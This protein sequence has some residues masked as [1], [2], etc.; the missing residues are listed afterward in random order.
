MQIRYNSFS[1]FLR[2]KFPGEK[3]RKIPINAGFQ[4]PNKNG[5]ISDEGCIFC[6]NYGS[7]PIKTF[8]KSIRKQIEIFTSVNKGKKFIAYYQAH[9]NTYASKEEIE[10]KYGIPFEYK[11]IVGL[12]IG[13]RPD[14][15]AENIYPV[16]EKIAD[17]TYLAVELGLQSIHAKSLDLLN[18]NHSYEQFL[19]TFNRLKSAGID[20]I[21]HLIVGIP[22]EKKS[23]M[24]ATVKEMNRIKPAG[25]KFHLLHVLK[26]TKL[27]DMYEDGKIK[28]MEK[29]D[30]I[31]TIIELLA[32]LDKEIVVHRIT[33]DRDSEIFHAPEWAADKVNVINEIH[34]RM[35]ELDLHQ[36]ELIKIVD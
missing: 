8:T 19:N 22:G 4:C 34:N 3:I 2:N 15:I 18:R 35:E 29:E 36:G 6:D 9:T 27:F 1:S 28:L 7:G 30:Y 5:D 14:S 10:E 33:G 13:T 21:V 25:V 16:I 17:K 11:D 26:N 20:V 12:F 24:L 32:S 31:D 23:D